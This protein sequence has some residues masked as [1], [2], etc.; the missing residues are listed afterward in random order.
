MA[1]AAK[2]PGCVLMGRVVHAPFLGR[3]LARLTL[4]FWVKRVG[5]AGDGFVGKV[6]PGLQALAK[7]IF[8]PLPEN[9]N[10]QPIAEAL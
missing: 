9:K 6:R 7:D 10:R 3:D 1:F 8:P 5:L 2:G 4:R